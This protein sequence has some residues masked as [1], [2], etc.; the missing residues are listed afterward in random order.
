MTKTPAELL[1]LKSE[2]QASLSEVTSADALE[3]WRVKYIGR[4]GAVPLLLREVKKLPL[5]E[6][7]AIGQ[8]ANALRREL[9]D[10]Y[11]EKK[12][13]IQHKPIAK[14]DLGI[15]HWS[16]GFAPLG[17]FHPITLTIR[18]IQD[19]VAAMGFFIVEGP[20][21]EEA[22]YNFDLLNIPL[23]HA[24]RAET[25]TFYIQ[26]HPKL[27][28]RTQ[29]SPVQLRAV[30][31]NNL[32]PPFKVVSP[33]RVFRAERTD[34]THESTFYQF[35]GLEVGESITL[36]DFKGVIEAFYSTFFGRDVKIRLRPSY[37][38]FVEPGFEVDV[39]CVFCQGPAPR[40]SPSEVGC[41]ICKYTRWIEIMGAGMVHPN[42]LR[43]MNVD[44]AKYQGYAFGGAIDRLA[45]L[46]YGIDD[47]R[48]FWSGDIRFLKQFS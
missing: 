15:G 46:Q 10:L 13:T 7:K 33:G 30:L 6:R 42:V 44:P 47:I 35:E 31:E 25:D 16:L 14:K 43:N 21:V 4:K 11:T 27:V 22:Q 19:I 8:A 32:T 3:A 12:Q 17:H 45:M 48:L 5:A 34:A 23:E 20:E 1:K 24:A 26:D 28:L 36:A 29:T 41:R 38:P 40:S 18:R 39:S 2:A 9:E 37:F